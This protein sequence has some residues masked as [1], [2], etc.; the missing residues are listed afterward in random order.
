MILCCWTS[1]RLQ[2]IFINLCLF[3]FGIVYTNIN[4]YL[5]IWQIYSVCF[6]SYILGIHF[7]SDRRKFF[8]MVA[9][10]ECFILIRKLYP[11]IDIFR[12]IFLFTK[13]FCLR[14]RATVLWGYRKHTYIFHHEHI[15]VM[16]NLGR[17]LNFPF[18][19]GL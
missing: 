9:K 13:Y 1:T 6:R 3:I 14:S 15:T 11:I 12:F 10:H 2:Y 16:G 8:P 5:Y 19:L 7:I 4:W 17:P 18:V